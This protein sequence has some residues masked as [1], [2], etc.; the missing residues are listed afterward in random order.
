[1]PYIHP[2]ASWQYLQMFE[3]FFPMLCKYAEKLPWFVRTW[4]V[5]LSMLTVHPFLNVWDKPFGLLFLLGVIFPSSL[6]LRQCFL[7]YLFFNCHTIWVYPTV[8][9]LS[10]VRRVMGVTPAI[11]CT[12]FTGVIL[13]PLIVLNRLFLCVFITI[14]VLHT[15]L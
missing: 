9:L 14:W 3:S 5:Y 15:K 1:M 2:S 7:P 4:V 11:T 12:A 6:P 8:Q 10:T 13:Y